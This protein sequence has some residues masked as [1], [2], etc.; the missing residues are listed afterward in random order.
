MKEPETCW[1]VAKPVFVD[2]LGR[3]PVSGPRLGQGVERIAVGKGEMRE[4]AKVRQVAGWFT[5]RRAT[6]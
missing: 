1:D 4:S 2:R 5:S 3:R 6:V